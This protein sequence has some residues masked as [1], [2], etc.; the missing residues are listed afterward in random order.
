MSNF[1][2]TAA[3]VAALS[4][5]ALSASAASMQSGLATAADHFRPISNQTSQVVALKDGSTLHKY[6]DGKMAVENPYGHPVLVKE[7]QVLKA[8][9][10]SSI[11]MVGDEVARLSAEL[12]SK[13][14]M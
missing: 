10:G 1:I 9:D 11:T 4:A 8:A 14:H 7:G 2:K 12:Y 5:T 13:S 6:E 3:I